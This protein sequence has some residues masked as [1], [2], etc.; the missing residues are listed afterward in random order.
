MTTTEH[1]F[2]VTDSL[3]SGETAQVR[4]VPEPPAYGPRARAAK[5]ALRRIL[6]KV[7]VALDLADG[8]RFG[9]DSSALPR[10]V[11]HDDKAFFARLGHSPM[12]GLGEG[13]MAGE[14]DV[15][16]GTDLADARRIAYERV[17]G[18]GLADAHWRTDIGLAAQEGRITV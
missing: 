1:H 7:P 15:A 9:G 6:R 10:L 2:D 5:F 13:Y 16:P 18:V 14:W 3:T 11:L 8:S 4:P 17:A 12:I